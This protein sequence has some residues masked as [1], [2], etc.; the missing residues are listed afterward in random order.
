[1]DARTIR[2][3]RL[4]HRASSELLADAA[5]AVGKPLPESAVIG[6]AAADIA[7]P[8]PKLPPSKQEDRK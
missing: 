6:D 7:G 1:M 5:G 2:L 8:P 3:L 4:I